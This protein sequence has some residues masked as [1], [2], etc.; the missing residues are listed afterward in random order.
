MS[1]LSLLL[2][3]LSIGAAAVVVTFYVIGGNKLKNLQGDLERQITENQQQEEL[4]RKQQEQHL[5]MREQ[6]D[7]TVLELANFKRDKRLN[8]SEVLLVKKE[9]ESIRQQLTDAE[10]GKLTMAEENDRLRR[11]MIDLKAQGFDPTNNPR[12]LTAQIEEQRAKIR[13]LESE[14]NDSQT[15]LRSL[16]ASSTNVSQSSTQTGRSGKQAKVERFIPDQHILVLAAGA[17]QGIQPNSQLHLF[18]NGNPVAIVKV[19][20][21]TPDLCVVN[22]LTTEDSEG[23]VLQPGAQIEY[24]PLSS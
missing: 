6:L 2:R 4:L 11:E 13:E 12:K 14:L 7:A 8:D 24:M 23:K 20:K 21:V 22:I 1:A 16:F 15:V 10:T 3:I 19:A 5:K 9:L 18:S 17:R